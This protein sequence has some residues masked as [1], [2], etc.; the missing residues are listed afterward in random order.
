LSTSR[1][2]AQVKNKLVVESSIVINMA[3]IQANAAKLAGLLAL[4]DDDDA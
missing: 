4:S 2:H 3:H 1:A